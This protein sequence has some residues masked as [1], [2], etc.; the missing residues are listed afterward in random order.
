MSQACSRATS[1]TLVFASPWHW[2]STLEAHTVFK[3]KAWMYKTGE[4]R[5]YTLTKFISPSIQ[6]AE[7]NT[8]YHYDPS[9]AAAVIFIVAFSLSGI[10][11]TYQ[12]IRLRSWYFIPFVVGS[13]VE[14]VGYTGRAVNASEPS[15]EWTDGPYIIQALF[16]LLGPPFY[17]ASIYMVLGRLIRLLKAESFSVVRLNWL[18]KIF[19]FGDIASIA[20]Q[21]MGGG[22]L[23]GAD[24]KSAKDRG[25]MIII[26]GLFIQ[27][28]FF[29]MFIIV[30]VIFHRRIHNMPT[31]ASLKI[32]APWKRL[33]IVLYVSSGL[34]MIRSIFR[35]IE[36]IMGEDGELM[37][38]EVYIYVFDGTLML[39]VSLLFNWF[40]PSATINKDIMQ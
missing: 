29:G 18:T 19:L 8:R 31:V 20:A 17:A 7:G 38:K 2:T 23:A 28:I 25:Q 33:L 16:L 39:L 27:L 34:I 11:H 1:V 21:G 26:I 4:E 12:V 32:R 13:I 35:V 6:M 36:Y 3:Y 15:G 5:Q 37:A 10:Y 30:T 40:H 9:M 22:M 14:V 24:S